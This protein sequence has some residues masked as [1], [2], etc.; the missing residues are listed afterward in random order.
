MFFGLF[1][2]GG[3]VQHG[4]FW[5]PLD[6]NVIPLFPACLAIIDTAGRWQA[7]NSSPMQ[8]QPKLVPIIAE[9]GAETKCRPEATNVAYRAAFRRK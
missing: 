1:R 9:P 4:E 7:S 8:K 2:P 5:R 3:D 6:L